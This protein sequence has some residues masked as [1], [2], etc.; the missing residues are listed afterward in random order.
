MRHFSTSRLCPQLSALPVL[1]ASLACTC[2]T[3]F[4]ADVRLAWDAKTEPN[5]AGYKIHYG[6]AS[7]SYETTI[8][9]RNVTT[10][11]VTQLKPGTYYFCVTA[12]YTSG[13]ETNCSNEV[14]TTVLP[15][16]YGFRDESGSSHPP[17]PAGP[18]LKNVTENRSSCSAQEDLI[19]YSFR[20]VAYRISLPAS[21]L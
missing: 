10:Y 15:K 9:V 16:M 13:F 21:P 20:P 7:R 17:F 11:T 18:P 2:V 3:A 4:S 5:L 19:A 14:S 12:Y 8:D 6:A 1:A